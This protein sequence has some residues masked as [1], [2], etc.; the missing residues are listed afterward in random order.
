MYV[1]D[2][3]NYYIPEE[4]LIRVMVTFGGTERSLFCF[5]TFFAFLVFMGL[6][7][8]QGLQIGLTI[9]KSFNLSPH[10]CPVPLYHHNKNRRRQ[11]PPFYLKYMPMIKFYRA[12]Y[13]WIQFHKSNEFDCCPS[14]ICL[15][16]VNV[17]TELVDIFSF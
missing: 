9:P 6:I 8:L 15:T 1:S 11:I 16:F 4:H 12:K 10:Q 7:S 5:F 17:I 3:T 13:I 2:K 14:S